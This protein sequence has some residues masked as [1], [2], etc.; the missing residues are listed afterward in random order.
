MGSKESDFAPKIFILGRH[1]TIVS[2]LI[3]LVV[4]EEQNRFG[5]RSAGIEPTG[6]LNREFIE[7]FN[8]Y[9]PDLELEEFGSDPISAVLNDH[10][11][12]VA[13]LSE[14]I[15][16]EAPIIAT[17]GESITLSTEPYRQQLADNPTLDDYYRVIDQIRE[18]TLPKFLDPLGLD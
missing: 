14:T 6:Q 12:L 13:Y 15:Q 10:V 16:R 17:T 18:S 3:E 8:D 2:P 7:F 11:Q 9:D 4:R 1:N 5:V